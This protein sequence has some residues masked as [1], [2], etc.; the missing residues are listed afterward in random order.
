MKIKIIVVGAILILAY[1]FLSS[2]E[3]V[4]VDT[5]GNVNGVINKSKALVQGKSFW[6]DQLQ[7]IDK[8]LAELTSR[9]ERMAKLAEYTRKLLQESDQRMEEFH[10]RY[11]ENRPSEEQVYADK[12]REEAD[13]I[14]HEEI[15][16]LL[17]K[18][19]IKRIAKLQ[20]IKMLVERRDLP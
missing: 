9:P 5:Y 4:V 17:E 16:K 18:F 3:K 11:P 14:E 13:K 12:L 8:E 1:L 15:M 7:E 19:R 20:K 2:P 6:N 10:E